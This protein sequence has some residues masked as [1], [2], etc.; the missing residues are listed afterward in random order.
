MEKGVRP[1]TKED[2][3]TSPSTIECMGQAYLAV[4]KYCDTFLQAFE[5]G[6]YMKINFA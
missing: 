1:Q 6:L 2:D 3:T 4:A 5:E